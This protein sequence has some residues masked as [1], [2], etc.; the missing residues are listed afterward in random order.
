[1]QQL[2]SLWQAL[3][4]RK[5][6]IVAAA[7]VA[8]FAAV[9]GLAS[10][11]TRPSMA[12]L[13]AGIDGS[14]AGEVLAALDRQGAKYEVRGQAIYVESGLR[15]RLRMD[16]AGQGL[17]ANSGEGYELLDSLSGFGTTSQMFDA[18]Y[19]RAKE[20]ELARTVA[21]LPG[22]RTVRVHI[23]N[24]EPR[25]FQEA[26]APKASVIVVTRDGALA[27][28]RARALRFLVSAAVAGMKPADV[29]VIDGAGRLIASDDDPAARAG[30]DRAAALR[31]NVTRLLEA[32]VGPGRAVVEVSVDTVTDSESISE[33]QIDPQ[34]R[35]A[36]SSENQ[37]K[38]SSAKDQ[39]G[40][41]VSVA[42]NLP[43]GA[44]Q[45][46][47]KFSQ[48]SD[49]QTTEKVNYEVSETRRDVVKAPG[50]VRRLT[51]AVLVDGITTLDAN[52][53][54]SWSARPDDEVAAL[55]EL[56]AAAVGFDEKRGDVITI[57]SLAFE[58][59]AAAAGE[60]GPSLFPPFALDVMSLVQLA[61]LALVALV[62]GLFVLRPILT[63]RTSRAAPLPAPRLTS[64]PAPVGP[65]LT[66]EIDDG[67]FAPHG[68]PLADGA[69]LGGVAAAG[70]IDPVARLRRL[71][72]ERQAE[73]AEILK[74]WMDQTG[75]E[76]T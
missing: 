6:L 45:G 30:D 7:T 53:Q 20:G 40:S 65:A 63:S 32:R 51:V 72:T 25:G 61:V 15:D 66:G 76:G 28:E 24:V 21:S 71:I 41:A 64:G 73:S 2:I 14:R 4:P 46:S 47:G 12:L 18:A 17:P 35:V 26:A 57:K 68:L 38:S 44:A 33:R 10:L 23:S 19:W 49:S 1:M 67:T 22:I 39:G 62:L 59:P 60:A 29:A 3:D 13:Y 36:I 42:S 56:V 37:E 9:Y 58:P 34:G 27:P 50:A 48:S 70:A 69:R 75:T 55:R 43:S 11:A 54:S 5:R 16:L 8:M 74:G 52:G 31:D